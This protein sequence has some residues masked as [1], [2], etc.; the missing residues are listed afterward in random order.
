M[1]K[2]R[3]I[4]DF[5]STFFTVYAD[6]RTLLRKPSALVVKRSIRPSVVAIGYDAIKSR[7]DVTDEELF[8]RPVKKGAVAHKIG[9]TI[10]IKEYLAEAC[11]KLSRPS[12]CVLIGC[13]LNPEQK[14]EIEK[15]FIDAGITDVF[16]MESLLGLSPV[17]S[18][19]DIKVGV[20]IGGETT[21]VGIFDEGKLVSGYSLDIGS[22]TVNRKIADYVKEN[23]KLNVSY[24]SA[25]ELKL[26]ASSLYNND[27]SKCAVTGTDSITGRGKR[28]LIGARE[29][30]SSVAYVYGRITKVIDAALLAAPL[31]I[32]Q[33]VENTGILY[34]GYGSLQ[35]GFRDYAYKTLGVPATIADPKNGDIYAGA[36]ELCSDKSFVDSYLK[37]TKV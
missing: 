20:I 7:Y 34:A 29:L 10:L 23:Y 24:E 11:G 27:L 2:S 25:E 36:E 15:V 9:C 30:Y 37:L 14:T 17:M 32:L 1:Q 33:K 4:F 6:G 3:V 21:E 28:L 12:V 13:G 16:L 26:K 19:N 35:E 31:S 18:R 8:L 5:G 22:C